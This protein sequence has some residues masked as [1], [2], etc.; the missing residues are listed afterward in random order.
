VI[1]YRDNLSDGPR[2]KAS[3]AVAGILLLMNVPVFLSSHLGEVVNEQLTFVPMQ[4]SLHPFIDSYTLISASFFHAD[5]LHLAGNCLFLLV[6]GTSLER[7]FGWWIFLCLF[8]VLGVSGF[9]LEW[10][11]HPDS[12]SRVLGSSGAVAALMGAYMT[13]FPNAR[14]RLIAFWGFIWKRFSLP[15][16]AF[17]FYWIGSQIFWLA[18]GSDD[19]VA[20]GVHVGSFIA[21]ALGGIVWKTSYPSAEEILESVQRIQ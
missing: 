19:A 4:F 11:I 2:G 8:P 10:I 20:Y 21:G 13:L 5:F 6:F 15:A 1:P 7:L 14:I 12:F 16:W 9:L 17:L 3:L 18:D